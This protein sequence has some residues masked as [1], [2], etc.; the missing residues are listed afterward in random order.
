MAFDVLIPLPG[1]DKAAPVA[2][3]LSGSLN[4][5]DHFAVTLILERKTHLSLDGLAAPQ[6][7]ASFNSEY[8]ADA[9]DIALVEQFAHSHGLTVLDVSTGKRRVILQGT[10]AAL[11][12]AF[13]VQLKCYKSEVTGETFRGRTGSIS[14]PR[15]LEGV[16][17]AVLGLDNRPVA[18]A[19]F[20]KSTSSAAAQAT[21]YTPPQVAALYNF[22]TGVTGAGQTIG[23]IELGGGYSPTDLATYFRSLKVT[24]PS[25]TAISVDGG[26]N[27]PGSDA[28]GEVM[29]DIEV[30]GSIAPGAKIAVYF[31][32]NTDQG[33][34]DAITDAVHDTARKPSIISISWAGRKI[35]GPRNRK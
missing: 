35:V 25:V 26:T 7:R 18:K 11:C 5:R 6:D 1:S 10:T 22:P 31:A 8:G 20:R 17:V 32:P 14:I 3:K 19:H 28:D 16:V 2:A 34:I 4:H 30:A 33:F 15:E 27:T 9:A 21:S 23:I 13:D 24:A 29:L 12:K